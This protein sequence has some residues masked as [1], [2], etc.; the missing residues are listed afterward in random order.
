MHEFT[1]VAERMVAGLDLGD[2][3]S[4][5]CML[6]PEGEVIEEGRIATTRSALRSRFE[7]ADPMLV[8][9]EVG[10]HSA[11]VDRLLRSSGHRTIVANA[12]QVALIYRNQRKHD[13]KDARSLAELGQF[14]PRLLH[15]IQ[16]RE[17]DTQA[18]RGLI[19]SRDALVRS[20]TQ[21][22]NHVRGVIKS[23][24]RRLPSCSTQ[25][26]PGK[27][28]P[29]IP[30]SMQRSLH[31]MLVIIARLT[32]QI[33]RFDREVERISAEKYPETE[34]LRQVPGV[35]PLTALWFVLTI[36]DPSRFSSSRWVGPYLGLVPKLDQSGQQDPQL[37]ITRAG[38]TL[39]RKLLVGAAQYILGP[40]G[41]DTDLRRW[42]LKLAERGGKNA[43]KRAVVAVARKLAVLLHRLWVTGEVYEPLRKAKQ[44]EA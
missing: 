15:P 8:V 43:K 31:P 24:G 29:L 4:R 14:N 21:L 17:E 32:R 13:R 26:F 25:S 2:R 1:G 10:T 20:R 22:V 19:R 42:G 41:P 35:G 34:L 16:H 37:G 11:W 44:Q 40:F 12:G 27:V 36:E 39:A 6:D 18:V 30:P 23:A 28:A 38:D 3:F 5:F 7:S 33:R 9:F